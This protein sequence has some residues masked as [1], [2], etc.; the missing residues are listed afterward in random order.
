MSGVAG[1][2]VNLA[3]LW[4]LY[5]TVYQARRVNTLQDQQLRQ[6]EQA[7][8][9]DQRDR[10]FAQL[11]ATQRTLLARIGVNDRK[12]KNLTHPWRG[13]DGLLH[14]LSEAE[15]ASRSRYVELSSN[16]HN[17]KSDESLQNY[18]ATSSWTQGVR[19]TRDSADPFLDHIQNVEAKW[20]EHVPKLSEPPFASHWI[21]ATIDCLRQRAMAYDYQLDTYHRHL[22]LIFEW[23]RDL[24]DHAD[25]DSFIRQIVAQLSWV[26]FVFIAEDS[27]RPDSRYSQSAIRPIL[28]RWTTRPRHGV[29]S[30]VFDCVQAT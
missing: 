3:T 20:R 6:A 9:A 28:Q 27:M 7:A 24:P 18:V 16:D 12:L 30:V 13:I 14:L 10:S 8:D 11:M 22:S 19:Q 4:M 1:P 17:L 5:V 25:N 26:E 2:L 23:I 21:S 29:G 15:D